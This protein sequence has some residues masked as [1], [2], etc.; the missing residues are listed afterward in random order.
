MT[1]PFLSISIEHDN[2]NLSSPAFKLQIPLD[3]SL[4]N[5]GITLP[6]IY[7]LVPLIRASW[8]NKLFSLT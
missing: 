8:S 1:L 7:I 4:G 6:N 5:I 2:V 3:N